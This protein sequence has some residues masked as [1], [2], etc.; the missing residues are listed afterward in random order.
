VIFERTTRFKRAAKKLTTQ[1][2]ERLA[3]ALSLYEADPAHPSLGIKRMQG[4]KGIWEARAS[5]ALRFTFEK[6][7]GGILLRN[8]GAPDPTLR[9]P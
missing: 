9:R 1:D 5:D 7:D 8:V 4:T 3:K 2:R 6:I